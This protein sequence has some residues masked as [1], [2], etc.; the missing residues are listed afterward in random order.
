MNHV[1]DSMFR[2]LMVNSIR[3]QRTSPNFKLEASR[4]YG[5]LDFNQQINCGQSKVE[6]A[7]INLCDYGTTNGEAI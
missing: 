1:A 3:K 7:E 2:K 5:D 4:L 6:L